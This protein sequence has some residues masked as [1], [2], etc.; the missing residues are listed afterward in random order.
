V[1]EW[2]PKIKMIEVGHSGQLRH[3]KSL[4]RTRHMERQ[5]SL[6]Q[7]FPEIDGSSVEA[8]VT[9]ESTLLG[10]RQVAEVIASFDRAIAVD[11]LLPQPLI[12]AGYAHLQNQ[13]ATEAERC[14]LEA[15]NLD[16]D[17]P[18]ADLGLAQACKIL[19]RNDQ[20]RDPLSDL[21]AR[22]SA[23]AAAALREARRRKRRT[24]AAA[25]GLA[26]VPIAQRRPDEG[27][28]FSTRHRAGAPWSP[29]SSGPKAATHRCAAILTLA[30]G[31]EMLAAA[32]KELPKSPA[33]LEPLAQRCRTALGRIPAKGQGCLT[34]E[35]WRNLGRRF[36][37]MAWRYS[38]AEAARPAD[39][40]P[41]V[42]FRLSGAGIQASPPLS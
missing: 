30:I 42:Q 1:P 19:D 37:R 4:L 36:L 12:A 5:Q 33:S 32:E 21:L 7:R 15:L 8:P 40:R 22:R 11:P 14:F 10:Q 13:D 25:L 28:S 24:L 18:G 29:L 17:Q 39:D 41:P 20:A 26:E 23:A 3:A 38:D 16:R 31:R 9:L 34:E 6:A 2:I 35:G 27:R